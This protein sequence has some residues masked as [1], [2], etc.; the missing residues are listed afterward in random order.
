MP[1]TF[2]EDRREQ[3]AFY[4]RRNLALRAI[5]RIHRLARDNN[6]S[7]ESCSYTDD[8]YPAE[9]HIVGRAPKRTAR[10][11]GD[12]IAE[13]EALAIRYNVYVEVCSR[14]WLDPQH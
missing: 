3:R 14:H 9:V 10:V 6:L 2:T 8:D 4:K 7:L 1:S 5:R 13:I 12:V 11:Y